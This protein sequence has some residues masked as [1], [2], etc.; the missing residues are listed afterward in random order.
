MCNDVA[1]CHFPQCAK[2]GTHTE[3]KPLT[4]RPYTRTQ[5]KRNDAALCTGTSSH[6]SYTRYTITIVN[7]ESYHSGHLT[8]TTRSGEIRGPGQGLLY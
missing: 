5:T 2:V 1:T 4:I 7:F 8:L 6:H 3:D